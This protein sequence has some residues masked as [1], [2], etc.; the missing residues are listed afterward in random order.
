MTGKIEMLAHRRDG[1]YLNSNNQ[2]DNKIFEIPRKD[3]TANNNS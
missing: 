1:F 3:L 2:V